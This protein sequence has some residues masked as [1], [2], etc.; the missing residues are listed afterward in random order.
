MKIAKILKYCIIVTIIAAPFFWSGA[1]ALAQD[2]NPVPEPKRV[3]AIFVYQQGLPWAFYME[4]GM[5][6]ALAK[7][8]SCPIELNVEH[9]DQSRFPEKTYLAK[10]VDLY[11][12][13][14]SKQNLD[15][16]LTVGDEATELLSV[17]SEE[18]FGDTPLVMVTTN[19]KKMPDSLLKPNIVSLEWGFDFAKTGTLIQ[20]ILPET[21]NL[22]IVSGTSLTDQNMKD[23]AT[24]QLNKVDARFTTHYL[25]DLSVEELLVR[26][27]QLPDNSAI[28]FLSL[29]RD[30]NG[31]SFIPR[32]VMA[33]VAEKANAPTFGNIDLYLGHGI[34][35]GSLLSAAEQGKR[36]AAIVEKI[37]T[38]KPLTSFQSMENGNQ[39]MF[40]WRQLKRWSIDENRLPANSIIRYREPSLWADHKWEVV[41][42]IVILTV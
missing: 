24:K 15:L 35:G 39:I 6:L 37:V 8:S 4:E 42:V 23:V 10:V 40:D 27:T 3:L 12:Y 19:H 41:A 7:V 33:Q 31:K 38:G 14:Y 17:Y 32:E 20:D 34:V 29:F 11:R 36:Y 28:L 13:K 18:L 1:T 5:R 9:A 26:V 30:A 2:T 25:D 21:K 16:V 22:F